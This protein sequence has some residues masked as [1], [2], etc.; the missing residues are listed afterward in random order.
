M[1]KFKNRYRIPSARLQSWDYSWDGAYFITIC[2]NNKKHCFGEIVDCRMQL[3]H[4][5]IL[6]DVFWY[7]IKNHAKNIKL[8]QFVVMPNHVHGIIILN[9]GGNDYGDGRETRHALSLRDQKQKQQLGNSV[10]KI[11]GE[12]QF[13]PLLDHINLLLQNTPTV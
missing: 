12:I 5:G 4:I 13:R 10:F 3:S 2:T 6:A 7:E 8:G 1:K 9:N 11:R